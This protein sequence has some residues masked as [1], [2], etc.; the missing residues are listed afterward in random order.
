[1]LE[2]EIEKLSDEQLRAKADEFRERVAP[3]VAK[4]DAAR[5]QR[6]EAKDPAEQ[7]AADAEV[8]STH[9]SLQEALND[10]LPEAFAVVR[11][12]SKRTIGLRH[13]DVQMIGG[14]VLHE[15]RIAEMATGEGKTLVAS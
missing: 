2:P 8:K 7:E 11:E 13:F 5:A 15:G 1:D 6:A 14:Q 4:I 9:A 3:Y 10:L 12:A